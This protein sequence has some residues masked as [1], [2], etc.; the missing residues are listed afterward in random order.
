MYQSEPILVLLAANSAILP[1]VFA[2]LAAFNHPLT[3][4]QQHAIVG[5]AAVVSAILARQSVVS[6][7]NAQHQLAQQQAAQ[8]LNSG[9]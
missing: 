6:P 8:K 4:A 9:V 3:D 2:L 7:S 1:S 5:L